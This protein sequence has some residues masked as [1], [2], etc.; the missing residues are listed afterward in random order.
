MAYIGLAKPT[1]A[2]LTEPANTYSKAFRLGK[3]IQIDITPA[4]AEGSLYGDNSK[5]EYDKEFNYADVVFNTTTLP[6][7]AHT[8][9][10]GHTA[11]AD[12]DGITFKGNDA[13]GYVGVGFYVTEVVDGVRKYVASWLPK[14]KFTEGAESYK[15]KGEAIEYQTPSISGQAVAN[16]KGIWKEVKPFTTETEAEEWLKTK[17]GETTPAQG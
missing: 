4:Y 16:S 2:Q 13:A 7:D 5:A 3:A 10:F 14:V 11:S 9:M 15:T 8:V 1:V 17:S 12:G 6:I